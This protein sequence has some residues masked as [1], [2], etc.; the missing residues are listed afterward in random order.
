MA[1]NERFEDIRT[2]NSVLDDPQT[3]DVKRIIKAFEAEG[4]DTTMYRLFEIAEIDAKTSYIIG[5][6]LDHERVVVMTSTDSGEF[7]PYYHRNNG[8]GRYE[9]TEADSIVA[10]LERNEESIQLLPLRDIQNERT[11]LSPE[12]R[13]DVNRVFEVLA[14]ENMALEPW[15]L[16]HVEREEDNASRRYFLLHENGEDELLVTVSREV[17]S[18][19]PA[20]LGACSRSGGDMEKRREEDKW[21]MS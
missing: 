4:L 5:N 19:D 10:A 14:R 17:A 8:F 12:Q 3:N 6:G 15:A 20:G 7:A 11:C 21:Y 2:G 16:V 9:L 13:E 1:I 18:V